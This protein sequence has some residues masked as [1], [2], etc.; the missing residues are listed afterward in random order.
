MN[1]NK[2]M[3]PRNIYRVKRNFAVLAQQFPDFALH[4]K[5]FDNGNTTIDFKDP[6]ALRALTVTLLKNDF[7]L[8]VDLPADRLIPAIPQRLNYVLW[9][10]DLVH[11]LLSS[12]DLPANT[13]VRGIDVGTG[14]S[15]VFPLLVCRNN[16]DW[17]M[18][19]FD[20][21]P[22]SLSIAEQNV[23]R[24]DLSHRI[25][26]K[27]VNED[28]GWSQHVRSSPDTFHF[29]MCNPPFFQHEAVQMESEFES[30]NNDDSNDHSAEK[31]VK[32]PANMSCL[33][34][35][36]V[37]GGE[38]AFVSGL[39]HD[40]FAL[41]GKIHIFSI[42]L[43]RKS[44]LIS[45]KKELRRFQEENEDLSFTSTEFCQGKT[46][47]WGIA[48]SFTGKLDAANGHKIRKSHKPLILSP[49]P[50]KKGMYYSIEG[51]TDRIL[52][53]IVQDL[54]I[55]TFQLTRMSKVSSEILLKSLTNTWS[56]QRR[57]KREKK[58]HDHEFETEKSEGPA[59][60]PESLTA[61][62]SE[63]SSPP[64]SLKRKRDKSPTDSSPD[65]VTPPTAE[66]SKRVKES[67]VP[68]STIRE[69]D[70]S[71]LTAG[72]AA[73]EGINYLLNCSIVLKKEGKG[74]TLKVETRDS[75]L[76]PE[77]THQ[78]F[79]YLKNKLSEVDRKKTKDE[80]D[81]E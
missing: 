63:T 16:R 54:G 41:K 2:F 20:V 52:D 51:F 46:M 80:N 5:H 38:V 3:H 18:T 13:T 30:N 11:D 74:I 27:H 14:A 64:P 59:P 43:G 34:E 15:C 61:S 47:R 57:K 72:K 24:N 49:I 37:A 36:V 75:C 10:E 73:D 60:A 31:R 9:M 79:Q 69:R 76:T 58:R 25:N 68:V 81:C 56:N 78:I 21:D 7:E 70:H 8:D 26:L 45:L 42:M 29:L 48:W 65:H 71:L 39:I 50:Y 23:S 19:G 32:S 17:L 6:N 44:S 4:V 62:S 66:C 1:L 22:E 40:S 67:V 28:G 35:A 33:T 53:L 77:S 55:K 12:L